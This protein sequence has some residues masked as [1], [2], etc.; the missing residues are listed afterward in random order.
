MSRCSSVRSGMYGAS[1]ATRRRYQRPAR[2]RRRNRPDRPWLHC[3]PHLWRGGRVV[4]CGGLENRFGRVRPTRVRIPP[5]PLLHRGARPRSSFR[6]ALGGYFPVPM[7]TASEDTGFTYLVERSP[8]EV[9][10]VGRGTLDLAS[11]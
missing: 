4:E 8:D 10:L 2:P 11:K 1:S 3:S 9:R 7:A 6:G 5:P